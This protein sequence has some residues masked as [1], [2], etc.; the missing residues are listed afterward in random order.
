MKSSHGNG[1]CDNHCVMVVSEHDTQLTL[2]D[3]RKYTLDGQTPLWLRC[4]T[5]GTI[6][7]LDEL[8]EGFVEF[9]ES[10]PPDPGFYDRVKSYPEAFQQ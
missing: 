6:V 7:Q 5:D 3:G 10:P 2:A 9:F 1:K 4:K 8:P